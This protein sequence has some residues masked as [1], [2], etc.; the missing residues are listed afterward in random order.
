MNLT[1]NSND[2]QYTIE[3][4]S[5]QI[6]VIRRYL[7][8]KPYNIINSNILKK[9]NTEFDN[10][11]DL[12]KLSL[13][14]LYFDIPTELFANINTNNIINEAKKILPQHSEKTINDDQPY[15]IDNYY[16]NVEDNQSINSICML[17]P[18]ENIFKK[19]KDKYALFYDKTIFLERYIK[20]LQQLL[21]DEVIKAIQDTYDESITS[22]LK[23][24]YKDKCTTI[25]YKEIIKQPTKTNV[26]KFLLFRCK[27]INYIPHITLETI[28]NNPI[29][30]EKIQLINENIELHDKLL[31]L[32]VNL[33]FGS[34]YFI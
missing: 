23:I 10:D 3:Q 31:K 2:I 9:L 30:Q 28:S 12:S 33:K 27:T 26:A 4:I 20:K 34:Y 19:I 11:I 1:I 5:G 15:N 6:P 17:K 8:F 32:S 22:N 18:C 25:Y 7:K 14:L 16:S 13:T 21:I 29:S 24:D